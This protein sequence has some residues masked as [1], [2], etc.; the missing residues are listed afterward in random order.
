MEPVSA[1]TT[2]LA[3]HRSGWLVSTSTFL[4]AG[5]VLSPGAERKSASHGAQCGQGGAGPACTGTGWGEDL[6]HPHRAQQNPYPAPPCSG[7]R[8]TLAQEANEGLR[9]H[10]QPGPRCELSCYWT[11]LLMRM[12]TW[13]AHR[14]GGHMVLALGVH[15][16]TLTQIHVPQPHLL[17]GGSGVTTAICCLQGNGSMT[18]TDLLPMH[19]HPKFQLTVCSSF[20]VA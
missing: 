4:H 17:A 1:A 9:S 13:R 7:R 14:M 2:S 8:V 6:L 19:F 20:S 12:G 18:S 11:S 3:P 10:D 16:V 5:Q 15:M